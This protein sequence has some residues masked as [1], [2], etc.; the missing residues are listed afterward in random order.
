MTVAQLVHATYGRAPHSRHAAIRTLRRVLSRRWSSNA[1][2]WRA[3]GTG[4]GFA[5]I[6][7]VMMALAISAAGV[8]PAA[9]QPRDD[10]LALAQPAS[11]Q[12]PEIYHG[13]GNPLIGTMPV[14]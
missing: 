11:V 12:H 5:M 10:A 4:L 2:L 13:A 9:P 3:I 6:G 8:A 7:L 1:A 14:P